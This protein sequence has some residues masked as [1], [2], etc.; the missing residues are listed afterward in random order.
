METTAIKPIGI[1]HCDS[2]QLK[3]RDYEDNATYFKP[4]YIQ[5]ETTPIF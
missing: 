2:F 5:Q 1:Y 3:S 4:K